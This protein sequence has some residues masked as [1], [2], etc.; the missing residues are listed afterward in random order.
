MPTQNPP[1]LTHPM[2]VA[3]N[4]LGYHLIFA[5]LRECQWVKDNLPTTCPIMET[6][7]G[8][9]SLILNENDYSRLLDTL[10]KWEARG[11]IDIPSNED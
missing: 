10:P 5:T 2:Q 4:Y 8:K 9:Y 1:Y 11:Y 6:H 3:N 7:L